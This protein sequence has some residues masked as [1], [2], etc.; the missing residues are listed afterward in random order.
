MI[1]PAPNDDGVEGAEV[2]VFRR[3]RAPEDEAREIGRQFPGWHVWYSAWAGTWD[4][5]REGEKPYFGP[6]PGGRVFMVTAHHSS[7]LVALLED[8]VRTDIAVGFPGWRV[9]R[10][11]GGW[12]ALYGDGPYSGSLKLTGVGLSSGYLT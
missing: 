8:Q 10:G 1:G 5:H 6:V 2:V 11:P 7:E 4:A 9:K 12:C 3:P